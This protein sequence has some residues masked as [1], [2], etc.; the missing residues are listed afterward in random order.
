M[1]DAHE[2]DSRTRPQQDATFVDP[3]ALEVPAPPVAG[4]DDVPPAAP[5]SKYSKYTIAELRRRKVQFTMLEV[6]L[7]I[8]AIVLAWGSFGLMMRTGFLPTFDVGYSWFDQ[9]IF[10][11]FGIAHGRVAA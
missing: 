1:T 8:L 2:H 11:F 5:H 4:D 3:S 6:L 9:H 10:F 7:V